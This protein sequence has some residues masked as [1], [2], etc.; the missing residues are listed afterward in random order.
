MV[1]RRLHIRIY[2]VFEG[3]ARQYRVM[4]LMLEVLKVHTGP[5]IQSNVTHH[6][7]FDSATMDLT[8]NITNGLIT[9]KRTPANNEKDELMTRYQFIF[10]VSVRG[11]LI[12]VLMIFVSLLKYYCCYLQVQSSSNYIQCINCVFLTWTFIGNHQCI[13]IIALPL[14]FYTRIL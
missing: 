11:V 1:I 10:Y 13:Y 7:L 14:C 9:K 12:S 4:L 2:S 6:S 5:F 8:E 3:Y